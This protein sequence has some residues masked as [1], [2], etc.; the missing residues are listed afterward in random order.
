MVNDSLANRSF[1]IHKNMNL[2]DR[3]LLYMGNLYFRKVVHSAGVPGGLRKTFFKVFHVR[4]SLH[5]Q[6]VKIP[7]PIHSPIEI[8]GQGKYST[9]N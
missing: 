1:T 2:H 7:T 3:G 6:R 4:R 5:N 8:T 9:P